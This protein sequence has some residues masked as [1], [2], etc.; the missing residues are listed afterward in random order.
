MKSRAW[1]PLTFRGLTAFSR[2]SWMRLWIVQCWVALLLGAVFYM[3]LSAAWGPVLS[4]AL[5]QL[6]DE[7]G[8][9]YLEDRTLT[10]AEVRSPEI[11]AGNRFLS[12]VIDPQDHSALPGAASDVRV[13]FKKDHIELHAA[14]LGQFRVSYHPE[15]NLKLTQ[16]D[17]YAWWG[18][19]G[20]GWSFGI[21]AGA[22][23]ILWMSWLLLGLFYTPPGWA[24]AYFW[25][26]DISFV[27]SWKLA[28]AAVLPG[29]IFLG[30]IFAAY[31][32][33]RVSWLILWAAFLLHWGIGWIYW[34]GSIRKLPYVPESAAEHGNPF[35]LGN[36]SL[37]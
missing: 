24:L 26:R 3:T 10:W 25:D 6:P 8:T 12:L 1:N 28:A 19:W 34:I 37:E 14:L 15:W 4:E 5:K 13:V 9:A 35:V 31:G 27:G 16:E 23:I 20:K 21:L 22:L 17:V 11:L 30:V 32:L 18:A 36:A 7:P 33:G 29:G 2:S